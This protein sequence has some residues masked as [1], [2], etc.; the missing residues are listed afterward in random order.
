MK[1]LCTCS[2]MHSGTHVL[3][4]VS[5]VGQT[6]KQDRPVRMRHYS[7]VQNKQYRIHT[8]SPVDED[9]LRQA[10]FVLGALRH[11]R[12]IAEAFRRREAALP[13]KKKE[14]VT[15]DNFVGQ[16]ERLIKEYD[17]WIEQYLVVDHPVR[18]L[19]V[20]KINALLGH[21]AQFDWAVTTKSG[22]RHG[23]HDIA[24]EVCPKVPQHF[25]DFYHQKIQES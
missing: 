25:I 13:L 10:D 5:G 20:K 24:L 22:S 15:F 8:A 4:Q 6:W 7:S 9:L 17:P 19:Q 16:Y 14:R 2:V 12:R 21:D 23:T 18:A 1:T 3:E 11:P